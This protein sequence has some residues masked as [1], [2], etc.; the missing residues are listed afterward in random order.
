MS[1]SPKKLA[2]GLAIGIPS[3]IVLAG[4][5]LAIGYAY[6]PRSAGQTVSVPI[7]IT[8]R[9]PLFEQND[10]PIKGDIPAPPEQVRML[11][12]GD[13]MLDRNVRTIIDKN[14]VSYLLDQLTEEDSDFFSKYD[15]VGANL[16]GDITPGGEHR[17][18]VAENDFAFRSKDV[19]TFVHD[20]HFNYFNIANNHIVDQGADAFTQTQNELTTLGVTFS[21]CWDGRVDAN[22]TATTT[23]IAG[24]RVGLAGFSYVYNPIDLEK[25]RVEIA[26]LKSITDLVIVQMHGGTEYTH[27]PTTRQQE[28]AHAFVDAGADLVIGHHPHVIQGIEIYNNVPIFYSL[29]NFIFDQYFSADTQQGLA[30][31]VIWTP[32]ATSTVLDITLLPTQSERSRVRWMKQNERQSLLKALASW[33]AIDESMQSEIISGQ[34]RVVRPR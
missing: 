34:V 30:V 16:E 8:H 2:I 15:L 18:P 17:P 26:T 33:S 24:Q 7:N 20:Y 27:Q 1:I 31:G 4:I 23:T 3:T 14:S 10:Q 29:G 19:A 22:C 11:F 5:M 28:Y 12:F 13:V 21:G 32:Q 6:A 9:E 25:A